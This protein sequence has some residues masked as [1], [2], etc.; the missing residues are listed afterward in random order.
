MT[1]S[2][3]NKKENWTKAEAFKMMIY[4]ANTLKMVPSKNKISKA[5]KALS[6]CK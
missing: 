3:L 6:N 2:D 1:Y 4:C 5:K